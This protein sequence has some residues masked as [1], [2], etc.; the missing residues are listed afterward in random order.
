MRICNTIFWMRYVVILLLVWACATAQVH[1]PVQL[2]S[3][4]QDKNFFLLAVIQRTPKVREAVRADP[5][6]ARLTPD[7]ETF[8]WSESQAAEA[9]KALADLYMKSDALRALTDGALR[10]SGMYVRYNG[11]AGAAFLERAWLDCVH[12]M[13]HAIDVYGLGKAPRY[14]AIDSI[15]YDAKSAGWRST[16]RNLALVTQLLTQEDPAAKG[17]FFAGSLR[18]ATELMLFNDRDEAGRFEPMEAGENEAAFHRMKFI[19]WSRYVYS[20][21][22]VPGAGPDLPRVALSPNG[23]VRDDVAAQRFRDG[24]APFILV[25]G[26]FVHPAHTEFAE[27]MEMKRDLMSRLKIPGDAILIDPHARHTTTNMRNAAR[28][29]YR[30]GAP[31]DKKALVS[32]DT[33]QSSYIEGAAF[34]KR[35][36]DELGYVPYKLLG[37]ISPFDLEFLPVID[38]LQAD[39][40]DPLD[41]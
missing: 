14:P 36:S 10:D 11:L 2:E 24:K 12:G 4:F 29:L 18:F 40:Q 20:V 16:L 22:V 8:E 17:L 34:A 23:R 30:Y 37:R 41:P 39:P 32:T 28:I 19:E 21:I 13:N 3:A 15:S 7:P 33:E 38:S 25:S 26:G 35:C 31:F 1:A 9:G 6:L 5:A 27:A